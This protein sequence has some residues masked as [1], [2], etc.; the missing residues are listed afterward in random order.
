MS[1][2]KTDRVADR[3]RDGATDHGQ[4]FCVSAL[5]WGR[6][7]GNLDMDRGDRSDRKDRYRVRGYSPLDFVQI[8]G[9]LSFCAYQLETPSTPRGDF[10]QI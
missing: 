5:V 8:L 6:L 9:H 7:Y 1:Y 3:R 4:L 10:P 2:Q